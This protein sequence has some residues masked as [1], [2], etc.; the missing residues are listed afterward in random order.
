MNTLELQSQSQHQDLAERPAVVYE[1][2]D[3]GNRVLVYFPFGNQIDQYP[4]LWMADQAG[5]FKNKTAHLGNLVYS[6]APRTRVPG[7]AEALAKEYGHCHVH[8]YV[9]TADRHQCTTQCQNAKNHVSECICICGGKHHGGTDH[10]WFAVGS[11]DLLI[12]TNEPDV[13]RIHWLVTPDNE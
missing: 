10:G 7:L 4:R 6:V 2:P 11:G 8:K 9:N 3:K 13:S 1:H 5:I 12:A